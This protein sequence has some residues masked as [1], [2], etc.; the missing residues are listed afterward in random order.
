[1]QYSVI[2]IVT[3]SFNQG[4]FIEETI[5]SVITQQGNFYIDYIIMDGKSTDNT[6]DILLKYENIIKTNPETKHIQGLDFHL[7]TDHSLI[8]CLGVSYRWFSEK[9][10]GQAH[11]INKGLQLAIG[12]I[13][14]WL[15]S[16]DTYYS[17]CLR[18]VLEAPWATSD[19]VYGKG[20]WVDISGNDLLLYPTFKPTIY[21]LFYKCTLCQPAVFW[22]R[23][24]YEE[25]G[26]LR[27]DLLLS[28]DYEYW[29]RAVKNKLTFQSTKHLLATSRMYPENK[30]LA[31]EKNNTPTEGSSLKQFY[32]KNIKLNVFKRLFTEFF[33]DR[34][35]N[36]AEWKL[37]KKLIKIYSSPSII[38]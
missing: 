5:L 22:K 3:P 1:M 25:L 29:Q 4:R 37:R 35:S 28:L 9:D 34:F 12:D 30:T 38:S 11:A 23:K 32:Y 21:S 14:C 17:N 33:V 24:V 15:N 36:L 8:K 31:A 27:E 6:S 13:L 26:E 10:D 19:F 16:D 7:P 20:M 18:N 2:S